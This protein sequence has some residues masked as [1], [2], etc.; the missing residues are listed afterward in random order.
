MDVLDLAQVDILVYDFQLRSDGCLRKKAIDILFE[1]VPS[2]STHRVGACSSRLTCLQMKGA[3]G[4][5]RDDD[6]DDNASVVTYKD[7]LVG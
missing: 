6:D 1:K 2:Y 7:A 5:H 3:L 4:L